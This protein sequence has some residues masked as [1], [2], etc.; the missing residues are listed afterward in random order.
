MSTIENYLSTIRATNDR[1]WAQV[2]PLEKQLR[3]LDTE[4]QAAIRRPI[5]DVVS[6]G[7]AAL[8]LTRIN[9][10]VAKLNAAY[11]DWQRTLSLI[12][13]PPP[14]INPNTFPP[15]RS[16]GKLSDKIPWPKDVP[17]EVR[18]QLSRVIDQGGIPLSKRVAVTVAKAPYGGGG[19]VI[20]FAKW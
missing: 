7:A 14:T 2:K 16:P 6:R 4:Y 9:A 1:M 19:V 13:P 17:L 18:R 10:T 3:D 5:T 11:D 15:P 20:E 8:L 12:T